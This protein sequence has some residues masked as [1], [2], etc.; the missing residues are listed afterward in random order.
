MMIDGDLQ[1]V[2]T[3]V[4]GHGIISQKVKIKFKKTLGF[5]QIDFDFYIAL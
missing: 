4:A 2:E 3:S 1:G 5:F